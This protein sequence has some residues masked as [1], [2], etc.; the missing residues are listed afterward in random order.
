LVTFLTK[1]KQTF[2]AFDA[3]VLINRRTIAFRK[4]AEEVYQDALNWDMEMPSYIRIWR[5]N[6][7]MHYVCSPEC[8]I[9]ADCDYNMLW[10][11]NGRLKQEVKEEAI[12]ELKSALLVGKETETL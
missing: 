9:Y 5:R 6:N 7:L 3:F 11:N 4:T 8:S 12:R 10:D 2:E 1:T